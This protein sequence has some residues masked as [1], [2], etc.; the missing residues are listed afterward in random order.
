MNP[1]LNAIFER[2]SIRA[3]KPN[4]ITSDQ[5]DNILS[6]GLWAPTAKNEQE[7]K[8][9]A[10]QDSKIL[11][12]LQKDF[13][14][15]TDGESRIFYYNAPTFI[16]L[17]GPKD[18][19]YTEVDAGIAVENMSL[20]AESLGLNTVIIGIIRKMMES[21]LGDKWIKTFDI[22]D[23]HKFVIGLAVGHKSADTPKRDRK[24]NRIKII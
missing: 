19:A 1:V 21:P 18:F 20:A 4:Q 23:N 14:S 3:Y 15:A 8:F 24:D 9:V 2:R 17:F 11:K 22:P 13:L 6:A 5:L 12:E 10:V 16:L 7:I